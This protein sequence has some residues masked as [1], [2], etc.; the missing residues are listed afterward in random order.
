M[1]NR[2]VKDSVGLAMIANHSFGPLEEK[3]K[4]SWCNHFQMNFLEIIMPRDTMQF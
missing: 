1:V 2:G 4:E 3:T